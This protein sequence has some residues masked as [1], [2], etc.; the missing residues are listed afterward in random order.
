[1]NLAVDIF[2]FFFAH[3]THILLIEKA[4]I[5][6]NDT[7]LCFSLVKCFTETIISNTY[8]RRSSE[9]K[10]E[11][12]RKVS[13]DCIATQYL[14]KN[15]QIM[16]PRLPGFLVLIKHLKLHFCKQNTYMYS[17]EELLLITLCFVSVFDV[18]EEFT[19][20]PHWPRRM[21]MKCQCIFILM[22]Y[23]R[24]M[25]PVIRTFFILNK[26]TVSILLWNNNS[27]LL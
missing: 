14:Y 24:W 6:T 18:W 12:K 15:K 13:F 26:Y 7:F 27:S 20:R 3:S 22:W 4:T 2:V 21:K 17:N 1:M 10:N 23:T 9:W 19:P 25:F 11:K 16:M 5:H 8:E